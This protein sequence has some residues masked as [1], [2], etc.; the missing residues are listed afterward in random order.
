MLLDAI[1]REVLIPRPEFQ[2]RLVWSNRHKSAFLETILLGY[3]FPEIY[4][5]AGQVDVDSGEGTEMLVDGQQRVTTLHQY[6]SGSGDLRLSQ[7]VRPYVELADTEKHDFLEYAVVVRDLGH[8]SIDEIR[9]IFQRINSTKYSL[10]AMEVA[11]ARF[12]GPFKAFAEELAQD[13]FF[14]SNRVFKTTEIRRMQDTRFILVFLVTIMS[15]YFNRDSELEDYLE[16]FNEDFEVQEDVEAQVRRVLE[17]ITACDFGLTSR[18]WKKAD[19]LTLLV[20]VHRGIVKQGLTLDP[21]QA[22]G[23]LNE[24]YA[25]VDS[26]DATSA[27][28]AAENVTRYHRAAIQATNDRSSRITRGKVIAAVLGCEAPADAV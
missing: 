11:N 14:E 12:D 3:P 7:G 17:F 15:T 22:G 26:T 21:D 25:R 27:A 13:Q 6:F 4:I 9:E 18:V 28:G 1:R 24:F 2:R 20:E 23:D 16:Q 19:L 10:N 5:A 8:K